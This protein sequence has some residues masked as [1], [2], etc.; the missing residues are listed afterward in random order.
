MMAAEPVPKELLRRV[1]AHLLVVPLHCF[2]LVFDTDTRCATVVFQPDALSPSSCIEK[3][4]SPSL[5]CDTCDAW[6]H[7]N[8]RH[9]IKPGYFGTEYFYEMQGL[10]NWIGIP[11]YVS[12]CCL[13]YH[14]LSDKVERQSRTA[15]EEQRTGTVAEA[16]SADIQLT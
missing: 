3:I 16:A 2:S 10:P 1:L 6:L 14:T 12:V 13:C 9:V 7:A 4:E 5:R 8:H 11:G 15:G